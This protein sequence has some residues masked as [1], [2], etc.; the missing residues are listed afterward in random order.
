MMKFEEA[1]KAMVEGQIR[2]SDVTDMALL[3][4]FREVP[5]EDFVPKAMAHLAYADLDLELAT[6]HVLLRPRTLAKLL[7]LADIQPDDGVLVMPGLT[8]YVP[9]LVHHLDPSRLDVVETNTGLNKTLTAN[10]KARG[11]KAGVLKTMPKSAKTGYDVMVIAGSISEIPESWAGLLAPEGRLVCLE[12]TG[13][14]GHGMLYVNT[15]GGL[16]GQAMFEA[17]SPWLEGYAPQS[18][19][20]F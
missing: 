9:T 11:I 15:S 6:G 14:V 8:G 12:R 13:P 19:F 18:A 17:T 1:R 3:T 16:S 2:T 10:L 7:E 20:V 5:R 4:A